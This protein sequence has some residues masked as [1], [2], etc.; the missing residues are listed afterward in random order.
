VRAAPAVS[1]ARCTK[2]NAH[3]H[4][5]SAEAVRPSPR[6]G[7]TAYNVLSPVTGLSCHRRSRE[8]VAS[9]KLDTSVGVPGPHDFAVRVCTVRLS[10]LP[11]PSRPGPT[12]VTTAKRPSCG[13]G[14]RELVALICP[15]RKAEYFSLAGWTGF[16]DLP[17]GHRLPGFIQACRRALRAKTSTWRRASLSTR[18]R[19]EPCGLGTV[20]G[21]HH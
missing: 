8:A 5:G 6:N 18:R 14:W 20:P 13:P 12:F 21:S 7:F 19:Q 11:R 15:T 9:R 3:E 2:Q 10:V 1:C 17:V 16:S 4:T